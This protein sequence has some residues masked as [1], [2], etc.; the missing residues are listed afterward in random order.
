MNT[1][2]TPKKCF[3]NSVLSEDG[4]KSSKR[5][6]G[7]LGF[8]ILAVA[9][10]LQIIVKFEAPADNLVSAIEYIT[11]AAIFGTV[12]EKFKYSNFRKSRNN[13]LT[14]NAESNE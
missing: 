4:D 6:I 11:M 14:N 5:V 12:I 2:K 13:S 8:I 3:I 9:L 1:E 10:I 7:I